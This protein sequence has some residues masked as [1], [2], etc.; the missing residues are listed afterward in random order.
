LK[1]ISCDALNNCYTSVV[2]AET[3]TVDNTAPT[4]TISDTNSNR[5]NTNVTYTLNGSDAGTGLDKIYFKMLD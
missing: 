2:E 5:R 1:A 4:T 3:Y